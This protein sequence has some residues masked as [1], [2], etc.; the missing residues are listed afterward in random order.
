[1]RGMRGAAHSLLPRCARPRRRRTR[2]LCVGLALCVTHSAARD[3]AAGKYENAGVCKNCPAGLHSLDSTQN[4]ACIHCPSGFTTVGT[5]ATSCLAC[6]AGVFCPSHSYLVTAWAT[7]GDTV[8]DCNVAQG[9]IITRDVFYCPPGKYNA[10]T[11]QTACNS[12]AA[13]QYNPVNTQASCAACDGG[14]Y[15]SSPPSAVYSS[16]FCVQTCSA[17]KYR[18]ADVSTGS[19]S[20]NWCPLGQ[21]RG[22]TDTSCTVCESP[23]FVEYYGSACVS[24]CPAGQYT[25]SNYMCLKCPRGKFSASTGVPECSA[26]PAGTKTSVTGAS[27]T[28]SCGTGEVVYNS[29]N[30][31]CMKCP[32][33]K[34]QTGT[35]CT[36]CPS[37]EPLCQN[38]RQNSY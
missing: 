13:G 18:V 23:N 22:L 36:A 19:G 4:T 21:Y 12:C 25:A 10:L 9:C 3:C 14:Q 30:N 20:C 11:A 32:V 16:T 24:G 15:S 33:G 5:G 26:C 2:A 34:Y 38:C 7:Y 29:D 6:P 1:M 8:F 17:G 37:G 27:C 35:A 28:A 31:L